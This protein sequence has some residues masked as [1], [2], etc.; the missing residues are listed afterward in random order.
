M[1]GRSLT[2]WLTRT[3]TPMAMQL[4]IDAAIPGRHHPGG[5]RLPAFGDR[6]VRRRRLRL[7]DRLDNPHISVHIVSPAGTPGRYH[8]PYVSV[9]P[10]WRRQPARGSRWTRTELGPQLIR[11]ARPL[12]DTSMPGTDNISHNILPRSVSGGRPGR[13]LQFL[14]CCTAARRHPVRPVRPVSRTGALRRMVDIW[15]LG[16]APPPP[17]VRLLPPTGA[18]PR[19]GESSMSAHEGSD[20][21]RAWSSAASARLPWISSAPTR[22]SWPS[23]T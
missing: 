9:T 4:G 8:K 2:R 16:T 11:A 18:R 13:A 12:C 5:A 21:P 22:P 17:T 6:L 14:F 7:R 23:I 15:P 19:S 1:T 20:T 3:P 10:A